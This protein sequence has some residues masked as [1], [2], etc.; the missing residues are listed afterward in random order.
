V[1]NALDLD[2]RRSD[3]FAGEADALRKIGFECNELDLRSYFG[4]VDGLRDCLDRVDLVWVVGGNTFVLARAMNASR[5]AD[6]IASPLDDGRIV[7]GGYSAGA[8]VTGPD[9]VGCHLMDDADKLPD[10]YDAA[11]PAT[12][13]GWLP[14]RIVPHWRSDHEESARAERAAAYLLDAGLPFQVLRDGR[15]FIVN[16][17]DQYFA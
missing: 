14:W 4:D 6:A 13:L 8:C 5:F 2:P 16:G 3:L 11:M 10:G 12:P 1:L 9:L 7:Y 17:R 15:V